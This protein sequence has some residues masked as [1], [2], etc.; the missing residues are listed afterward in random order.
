MSRTKIGQ[1]DCKWCGGT[2]SSQNTVGGWGGF[3][4]YCSKRCQ[5]EYDAD[6]D[7]RHPD[8]EYSADQSDSQAVAVPMGSTSS[9]LLATFLAW[10]FFFV[11]YLL[12]GITLKLVVVDN[13]MESPPSQDSWDGVQLVAAFVLSAISANRG[14]KKRT[15]T[16]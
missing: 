14:H 12:V 16:S 6:Y 13:V 11:L 4:G 15:H 10:P 5:S 3:G 8:D 2:Y 1:K 9:M 7:R